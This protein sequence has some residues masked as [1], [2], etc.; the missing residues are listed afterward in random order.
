M[1]LAV[2]FS[3]PSI[4]IPLRNR[5]ATGCLRYAIPADATDKFMGQCGLLR[6]HG[7]VR[8]R[9][10]HH[11]SSLPRPKP[12]HRSWHGLIAALHG[13]RAWVHACAAM[14]CVRCPCMKRMSSIGDKA[15]AARNTAATSV[16]SRSTGLRSSSS[17]LG[18]ANHMATLQPDQTSGSLALTTCDAEAIDRSSALNWNIGIHRLP[19]HSNP[20]TWPEWTSLARLTASPA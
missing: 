12:I 13:A 17:A 14:L 16:A 15:I 3:A 10:Q 11:K 18:V 8:C 6:W 1:R 9:T 7:T 20:N 4:E 2:V 5:S 19:R